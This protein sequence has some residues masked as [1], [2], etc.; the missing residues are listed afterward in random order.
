M[1]TKT[2]IKRIAL[3][4]AAALTL[5][6]VSAVSANAYTPTAVYTTMYDTT[7]GY[8][9]VGG[10]AT[11]TIGFDTST[12]ATVASSGVGTIVS[13]TPVT[14]FGNG[15]E[16]LTSVA[17]T[18]FQ[19]NA[20]TGSAGYTKEYDS[21][22][23]VLTSAVAGTQT[24]TITP[25]TSA[26]VPG[27]AV[28]KTITWTASG[29]TAASAWSAYLMD[30]TV[31][32]VPAAS[33]WYDS[34][35]SLSK[36]KGSATVPAEVAVIG[37]QLKDANGNGVTGATV[38]VTVS[39][40][41]FI[42][43]I[44]GSSTGTGTL[45]VASE[46]SRVASITTTTGGYVVVGLS[47]DG[48]AGVSTVTFTSGTVSVSR[49]VTFTGAV[50]SYTLTSL[51]GAYRVGTNGTDDS[52][53]ASLGIKVKSYDSAGNLATVGTFYAK[54]S[55]TAVATVSGSSH[56]V[57][58]TSG[59]KTAGTSFVAVTGVSTGKATITIQNTDPAGTTAPTVTKTIDIQVT[60]SVVNSVAL[61][62][63][64]A[65]YSPGAPGVVT[66][67]L[68]D[69]DGNPVA[70]G[71]YTGLFAATTPLLSD[72]YAQPNAT[73][74]DNAWVTTGIT[75][76]TTSGGVASYDFYA[77]SI[78]SGSINF[79]AGTVL[80]T[81]ASTV[82]TPAVRGLPLTA[83]ATIGSGAIGG[84]A[85]LALDAANAATDAANNAYDEAQNATQ[86]AQ[87][88]LAAVT[89]LAD[90]VKSLIA[91]VKSLTALVAKIKAKV[92]A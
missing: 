23:V 44:A 88:A 26:G 32:S 5:G 91:S 68:K 66:I 70:D 87:D 13:A 75:D 27:T 34:T 29:T 38:S 86:A 14:N 73:G 58:S 46:T 17:S 40:P 60:K 54:S 25:L 78:L 59:G 28:T 37:A 33:Y 85:A 81:T 63:D 52:L 22:T 71:T 19:H 7:N 77:P 47:G 31:T 8:Q 18:G 65:N 80:A 41:G 76:V 24:L 51:T 10:Q 4:A 57:S 50:A 56:D 74:A 64:K 42:Q 90:Q 84:D 30:T 72:L 21:V 55:N 35:V 12:V 36:D 2:T 9:V 83:S 20:A 45:T 62:L 67:T 92:G 43:G 89:A 1:S 3:V 53:T 11:V 48:T 15:F 6:G 16:T 61:S 69:A 82:Y 79:T 39:G 49:Q